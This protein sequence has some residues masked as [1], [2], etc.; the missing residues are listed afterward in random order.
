MNLFRYLAV[1]VLYWMLFY[2]IPNT[3]GILIPLF[4]LL[5]IFLYTLDTKIISE[6]HKELLDV[7]TS[8][9]SNHI[10]IVLLLTSIFLSGYISY[11]IDFAYWL[12]P[13]LSVDLK[14]VCQNNILLMSI[15]GLAEL[16]IVCVP[17]IVVYNI[18][19]LLYE[20]CKDS[21]VSKFIKTKMK[22]Q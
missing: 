21:L 22:K 12:D 7:T 5:T 16:S 14:N 13:G 17:I 8:Q 15:I 4:I 18:Y 9:I 6:K 2:Y 3:N 19:M 10:T 1:A 20:I 11:Q